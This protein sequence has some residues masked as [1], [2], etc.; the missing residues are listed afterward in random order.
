MY[1][2][3]IKEPLEDKDDAGSFFPFYDSTERPRKMLVKNKV[4][5]KRC[6]NNEES[7]IIIDAERAYFGFS[8]DIVSYCLITLD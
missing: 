3:L 4:D 6:E 7:L 2:S 5:V 1:P 8:T